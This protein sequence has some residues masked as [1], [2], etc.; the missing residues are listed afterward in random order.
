LQKK[1]DKGMGKLVL[2]SSFVIQ[3]RGLPFARALVCGSNTRMSHS[4]LILSQSIQIPSTRNANQVRYMSSSYFD[5]WSL[6][7]SP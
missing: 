6:A 3:N 2:L 7:K 1:K 5:E 4:G